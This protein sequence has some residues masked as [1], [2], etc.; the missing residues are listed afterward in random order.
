MN[1]GRED[2]AVVRHEFTDLASGN[3][4]K[5]QSDVRVVVVIILMI[6]VKSPHHCGCL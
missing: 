3:I 2:A 4:D 1:D 6:D 5:Y